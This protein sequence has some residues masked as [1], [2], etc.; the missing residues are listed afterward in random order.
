EQAQVL[1][2]CFQ[3][4][5]VAADA[6]AAGHQRPARRLPTLDNC[7][8][9]RLGASYFHLVPPFAAP[10]GP[11]RPATNPFQDELR[12]RVG[13]PQDDRPLCFRNGVA[14]LIPQGKDRGL[15][16][17]GRL[18][19]SFLRRHVHL[20]ESLCLETILLMD[21]RNIPTLTVRLKKSIL[22]RAKRLFRSRSHD[23][24]IRVYDEADNVIG[25][26]GAAAISRG[27]SPP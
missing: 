25:R 16:R 27:T 13:T 26:D 1:E 22:V 7:P 2:H 14:H 21:A 11:T 10:L 3:I 12:S 4:R 5:K 23:P 20:P 8:Q 18:A 6:D 24:V 15:Q 9:D 17:T 19:S